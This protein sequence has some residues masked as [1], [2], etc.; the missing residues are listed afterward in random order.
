MLYTIAIILLFSQASSQ[1]VESGGQSDTAHCL[2]ISHQH[3]WLQF[4]CNEIHLDF[5]EK[6]RQ[7]IH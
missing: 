4:F 1:A 7:A 6:F 3:N 5:P 2:L